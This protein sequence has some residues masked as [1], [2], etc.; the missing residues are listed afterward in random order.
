MKNCFCI[1]ILIVFA[2]LVIAQELPVKEIERAKKEAS[3]ALNEGNLQKALESYAELVDE[4]PT[5][6]EVANDV[7]VILA[8]LGRLNEARQVLEVAFQKHPK[9]GKAF[10]NLREILA[11]QA[12]VEYRKALDK[13]PPNTSLVLQSENID[14]T[15]K[16]EI[17]KFDKVEKGKTNDAL[18]EIG[19][20]IP[21]AILEDSEDLIKKMVFEWAEAWSKKEFETYI[22]FYSKNFKNKRAKSFDD[23]SKYRK[24]R[25][26]RRGKIKLSITKI[27]V[28][29]LA[30]GI[31]EVSFNQRYQSGSTRLFTRKKMRL[32]KE[33]QNW[34]IVFE[35]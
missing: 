2:K 27:K 25:V 31:A 3:L 19:T 30:D 18:N 28:D 13:K 17:V 35:G 34:K 21:L 32:K 24:P 5:N 20:D 4:Y 7:A 33:A 22:N 8:G 26:K 6:L 15:R 9:V 1:C 16:Y 12:S 11:R 23:W 29:I 10:I 14:L